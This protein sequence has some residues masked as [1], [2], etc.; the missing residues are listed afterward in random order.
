MITSTLL[1]VANKFYHGVKQ[2]NE[3]SVDYVN[4]LSSVK[5]INNVITDI[6]IFQRNLRDSL[7]EIIMSFE[8]WH[9]ASLK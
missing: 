5:N 4:K 2:S 6:L 3:K 9:N 7:I 1:I 8:R